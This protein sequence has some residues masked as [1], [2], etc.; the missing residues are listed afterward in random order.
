MVSWG[1][2]VVLCIYSATYVDRCRSRKAQLFEAVIHRKDLLLNIC[3]G[4]VLLFW[5][6]E[7]LLNLFK[8]WAQREYPLVQRL[9]A[10][11]PA[12][13]LFVFVF[14]FILVKV[15]PALDEKLGFNPIQYG[16]PI[17]LIGGILILIGLIYAMWSISVQ[18]FRASGTPL[19]I[20]ATQKLL[21]SG[22]FRQ[23]RNPMTFGTILFYLG[24]SIIIGSISAIAFVLLFSCLLILYL[25]FVE[26]RELEARF[27]E[28]YIQYKAETPFLIPRVFSKSS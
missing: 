7:L 23:C 11:I 21:I 17:L 16:G 27:G 2:F 13:V 26:E 5:E 8:K 1:K 19:P 24:I 14:P 3:S 10:L 4:C 25:K 9:L 12:G 6:G 18:I 28:E 15:A 22:P 20:M